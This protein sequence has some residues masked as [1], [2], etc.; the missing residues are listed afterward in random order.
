MTTTEELRKTILDC[1]S[2][3]KEEDRIN[4]L[5]DSLI[6]AKLKSKTESEE[7]GKAKNHINLLKEKVKCLEDM[8]TKTE[9]AKT[10]FQDL[11]KILNDSAKEVQENSQKK[12]ELLKEQ[13]QLSLNTLRMSLDPENKK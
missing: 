1:L 3:M 11:C 13:H 8:L 12:I 9:A 4:Y 10:K 5:I 2:K 6:E 7:L